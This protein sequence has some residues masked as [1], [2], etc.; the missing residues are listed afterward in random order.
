MDKYKVDDFVS[1]GCGDI[2]HMCKR[3]NNSK[4]DFL[5]VNTAQGK[6]VPVRPSK[7]YDM[8]EQ[9]YKISY[10]DLFDKRNI[11]VVAFAET[12]TALGELYYNY[13]RRYYK[14]LRPLDVVSFVT[15][16]RADLSDKS[17]YEPL[18]FSEEHSHAAAQKLY[19]DPSLKIDTVVFI[20]DEITTGNTIL[21]LVAKL[22]EVHKHIK[23]FYVLSVCNWQTEECQKRFAE[24][25]VKALALYHG[26][27]KD[28]DAK[29]DMEEEQLK[30]Y[31]PSGCKVHKNFLGKYHRVNTNIDNTKIQENDSL[32]YDIEN[33]VKDTF[34]LGDS[35][36]VEVVGTEEFMGLPLKIA[37]M[38]EERGIST[39]FHATT[40]SPIVPSKDCVITNGAMLTSAYDIDRQT[41]L[42]DVSN[43]YATH[44]VVFTEGEPNNNFVEEITKL[45]IDQG[46]RAGNMMIV[47]L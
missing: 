32:A 19:V 21:H 41:Y 5:F 12:A 33:Y 13:A 7:V 30:V 4:R 28:L 24:K 23:N 36:T 44:V 11:L 47:A 17:E 40:R 27:L 43:I 1:S 8:V 20:E 15:T 25:N 34:D 10:M 9:M 38:L 39:Y 31:S 3:R 2:I 37:A 22:K 18:C 6:H 14:T 29:M 35:D 16:T 46:V 45:Y 42:Y 26:Y